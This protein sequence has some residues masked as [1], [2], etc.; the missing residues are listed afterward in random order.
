[1]A[2]RKRSQQRPQP[3]VQRPRVDENVGELGAGGGGSNDVTSGAGNAA[4][5]PDAE[6]ADR[7][8]DTVNRGDVSKDRKKLFPDEKRTAKRK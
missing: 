7:A 6:L 8:G 4:G 2:T 1:M 3:A 5:I